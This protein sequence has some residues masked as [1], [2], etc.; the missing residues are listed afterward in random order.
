MIKKIFIT[1]LIISIL[2]LTGCTNLDNYV[3]IEEYSNEITLYENQLE[4][5]NSSIAGKD[6]E[7]E[8][9][10]KQLDYSTDKI[11]S[12]EEEL[13][14]YKRLI[15]NLNE[16]LSNV[17][18]GYASNSNWES[19]GFTAFSIEHKE[20]FYLITAGHAVHYKDDKIDTGVYNYFKFKANFSDEWIYPKLLTYENDYDNNIDYAVFYS[21]KINDGFIIDD[22]G[23][24]PKY[25]FGNSDLGINIIKSFKLNSIAGESGSPIVDY[26][27]EV[28]GIRVIDIFSYYT[29]VDLVSEAIDNL[30]ILK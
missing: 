4:E 14:K 22:E 9:L 30:T 19:V 24:T 12:D 11:D 1:I 15:I 28:I 29:R 17:Y 20:K 3:P 26:E 18:Y 7:I 2:V 21:D 13:L 27:G 16:L 10:N 5:A 23:D 25:V 6:R 8:K